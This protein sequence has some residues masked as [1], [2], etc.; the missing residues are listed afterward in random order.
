MFVVKDDF[1]KPDISNFIAKGTDAYLWRYWTAVNHDRTNNRS[2]VSFLWLDSS[3]SESNFFY[4]L[5]T[6]IQKEFPNLQNCYCWRIIANGQVRGQN[7]NWHTDHGENTALF[8]PIAW[9]PDWGGS[10]YFK[11]GDA[12]TEVEFKQN[13]L[14]VFDSNILHYGS[15][16]TVDNVLRVSIAF[17][18][19]QR[20][21]DFGQKN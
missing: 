18:L 14:V 3:S 15:G 19:R 20:S 16:P 8:F 7:I 10:T 11:I 4:V 6:M 12:E 17:N 21:T 9:D 2:F 13:R 5:W 1:F